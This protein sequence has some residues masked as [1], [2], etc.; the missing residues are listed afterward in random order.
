[1]NNNNYAIKETT[2][3]TAGKVKVTSDT[4]TVNKVEPN[5]NVLAAKVRGFEEQNELESPNYVL[6]YN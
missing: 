1:M 4:A 2:Q 3:V 5:K 6:G